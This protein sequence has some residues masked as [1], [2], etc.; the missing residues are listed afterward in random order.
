MGPSAHMLPPT[1]SLLQ[2]TRVESKNLNEWPISLQIKL[3]PGRVLGDW[4]PFLPCL[5]EQKTEQRPFLWPCGGP[6]VSYLE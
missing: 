5:Q 6:I 4:F 3:L 2:D 1:H